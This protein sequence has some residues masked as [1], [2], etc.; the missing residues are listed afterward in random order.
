MTAAPDTDA[1]S[2][3]PSTDEDAPPAGT[4]PSS[5]RHWAPSTPRSWGRIA[6]VAGAVDHP[7]SRQ[8][9]A[10]ERAVLAGLEA[11]CS[12]PV[13]ALARV[14]ERRLTLRVRVISPDGHEVREHS[15]S[16]DAGDAERLGRD[17]A[18]VLLADGAGS[19][20]GRRS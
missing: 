18:Q 14:T 2:G 12:A 5:G 19:L 15:R 1:D 16:G 4:G 6:A 9:A 10:A 11:G 7:P 8:E 17:A 13:G 3:L 20:M